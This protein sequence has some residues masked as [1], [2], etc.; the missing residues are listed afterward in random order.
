MITTNGN[1]HPNGTAAPTTNADGSG[2]VRPMA[3]TPAAWST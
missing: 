3:K 2:A 1:V